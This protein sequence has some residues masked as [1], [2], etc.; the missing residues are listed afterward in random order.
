MSPP[1]EGSSG[2]EVVRI[3]VLRANRVGD[4]VFALPALAAL[5]A[6][7][8]RARLTLLGQAWHAEF[9][10]GRGVVDEVAV[11]PPVPGVTIAPDAEAD[12]DEV[13]RF[14]AAM[15]ERR[16]DLAF[17]LHGGGAWSN[18]FLLRLGAPSSIGLRAADAA[19]LDRWIPYEPL[20][21]ERLRLLEAVGLA[22]APPP[23]L[24]PEL[25]VLAADE[26]AL[27]EVWTPP[28]A[29]PLAV[30]NPGATDPRRRWPGERF[31]AVGDA[32]AAAGAAVVVQGGPDERALTAQV[33]AAMRHPAAD[34]GG[35][36]SLSALA[37]LLARARLV[38]SND[39]GP[40]HLA[41]AVG[42]AT[43][44]IYWLTNLFVSGPLL[45][46]RHRHALSYRLRC[47]QCGAENIRSRC[48]HDPSF[49]T[50]VSVE[51]VT[52]LALAQWRRE[53]VGPD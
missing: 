30:L 23:A 33:V 2:G 35:R 9:L 19:P 41:Q 28:P 4:F 43:V 26:R 8:P 34:L 53:D 42:A 22:D 6:R 13:E 32:L 50:D 40:L 52:G 29:A 14:C 7:Y 5:R 17:Q 20:Q 24:A 47:P 49:V 1:P 48:P 27:A 16:F 38:V 11:L 51:E 12:L 36:L 46:A 44:G 18:P 31:A 21:N 37:A 25:P 15:R 10:A 45:S 39:T 3:A